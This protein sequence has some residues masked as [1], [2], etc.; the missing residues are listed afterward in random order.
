MQHERFRN[1]VAHTHAG[2]QARHGVLKNHGNLLS[3]HGRQFFFRQFQQVAPIKQ[4]LRVLRDECGRAGEESH[5][6]GASDRFAR[7]GLPDDAERFT[8]VQV[9]AHILDGIGCLMPMAEL[10]TEVANAEKGMIHG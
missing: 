10:N 4:R 2:I 1:L 5:E 8:G 9:K 3:A 7:T 6:R